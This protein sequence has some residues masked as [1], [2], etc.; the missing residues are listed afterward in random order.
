MCSNWNEQCKYFKTSKRY[1]HCYMH[2]T[3]TWALTYGE[4]RQLLIH[5]CNLGVQLANHS[6]HSFS[7]LDGLFTLQIAY[8]FQLYEFIDLNVLRPYLDR[9]VKVLLNCEFVFLA[10]LIMFWMWRTPSKCIEFPWSCLSSKVIWSRAG[11]RRVYFYLRFLAPFA[12]F[13]CISHSLSWF[14]STKSKL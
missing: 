4:V 1:M 12:H 9:G 6:L 7:E 8:R 14:S 13:I 2:N 5:R 3:H 11:H 10:I